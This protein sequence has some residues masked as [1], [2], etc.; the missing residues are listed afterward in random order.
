MVLLAA[1]CVVVVVVEV[2]GV[3]V[4]EGVGEDEL[5]GALVLDADGSTVA[6]WD[7]CTL[8]EFD[9]FKVAVLEMLALEDKV[10]EGEAPRWVSSATASSCS[11][12]S[13]HDVGAWWPRDRAM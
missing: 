1:V 9:G 7:G 3:V 11:L 4:G 10:A 5:D 6:E 8:G 2:V 12:R 13:F